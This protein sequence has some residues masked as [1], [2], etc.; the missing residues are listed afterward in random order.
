MVTSCRT[1]LS[2]STSYRNAAI[3]PLGT[4]AIGKINYIY[5]IFT[6]ALY[7]HYSNNNNNKN[8]PKLKGTVEY[9]KKDISLWMDKTNTNGMC[10][11]PIVESHQY[12]TTTTT[13]VPPPQGRQRQESWMG[14]VSKM[15]TIVLVISMEH[16]PQA[17]LNQIVEWKRWLDASCPSPLPPTVHMVLTKCDLLPTHVSPTVWIKFGAQMTSLCHELDICDFPNDVR[18]S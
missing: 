17:V 1:S 6:L 4:V 14:L 10:P 7:P 16:G 2:T 3:S 9:C 12:D 18:L 13:T 11:S 5:E 15:T 8:T